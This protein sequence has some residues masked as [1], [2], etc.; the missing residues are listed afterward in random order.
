MIEEIRA[1][2]ASLQ[3]VDDLAEHRPEMLYFGCVDARLDP[4]ADIGI[5][6]GRS[7]IFRNIAAMVMEDTAVGAVLEFFLNHIPAPPGKKKQIV[8]SG[9]T[10]CGGLKACISSP[11]NTSPDKFLPRY[12][13]N[14]AAVR[15]RVLSQAQGWSENEILRALERESVRQSVANLMAFDV[16]RAAIDADRVNIHG[17]VLD[18]HSGHISEMDPDTG[19]FQAMAAR[20]SHANGDSS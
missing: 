18:T 10:D 15:E 20:F 14:L 4:I 8:I 16:V 9:H 2:Q 19:E 6:K 5:A 7:I 3:S 12:L 1:R 11:W 17:W 13:S